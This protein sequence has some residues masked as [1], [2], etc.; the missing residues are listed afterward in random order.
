MLIIMMMFF[1]GLPLDIG[2]LAAALLVFV[3]AER[4]LY[5]LLRRQAMERGS[6]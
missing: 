4:A 5:P 6:A 2:R 3:L 1:A